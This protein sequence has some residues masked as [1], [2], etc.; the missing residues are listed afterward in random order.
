[1][2][3]IKQ[4]CVVW[5]LGLVALSP[6]AQAELTIEITRGVDNPT[7]IAVAPIAWRG[8]ALSENI[9]AIV[10]ADLERSGLFETIPQADMLSFPGS[11]R[12]VRYRDWSIL[13]AEYLVVTR[14]EPQPGNGLRLTF[15]LV[16]ITGQKKV[17]TTTINGNRQSV[18]DM[19]HF[20]SDKVYEAIKGLRGAFS[21]KILYVTS[22]RG[23][24][25]KVTYR[26]MRADAD[27]ERKVQLLSSNEPILSPSWSPDGKEIL[28]V[29]FETGRSAIFRQ[30][31]A[32]GQREQLTSFRGI[33]SAPA[34]SPDGRNLALTLS[35]DGNTEIYL[36]NLQT[37]R[38]RRLTRHFA[39]DTEP[40]WMPDSKT[41]LFTS[42]RGGGPQ[43]YKMD[44]ASG[45][46]QRL[47]F[48]GGYNA[49]GRLAPDGRT[50]VMVHRANGRFHIAAYD[51]VSNVFQVLTET[52]SGLDES[53]TVAPN[54]AMV[55]YATKRGGKGL[56]AGVSLDAGFKFFLPDLEKSGDV[57]EPAWSPF[58]R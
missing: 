56:L 17:F 8:A 41:L 29:S 33:N 39:A 3:Q 10:A 16:N 50:L 30:N 46:V 4:L 42:D 20:I 49:R 15:S 23:A 52:R 14:V 28:Y 53:P 1:M 36:F 32:T 37:R 6:V 35:K 7:R 25:G 24:N 38:F 12:E 58:L 11:A 13:K 27:G 48:R 55:L 40:T 44:I 5:L 21:T 2:K 57:R 51:L 31:V 19:A 45:K 47:T 18:R 43:I 9:S 34:W 54:G 26:L 22:D